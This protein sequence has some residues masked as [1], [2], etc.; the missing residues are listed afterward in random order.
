VT[1]IAAFLGVIKYAISVGYEGR[2]FY[3]V[4]QALLYGALPGTGANNLCLLNLDNAR[5]I[6]SML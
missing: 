6:V 5:Q 2:E 1:L 3:L 4:F